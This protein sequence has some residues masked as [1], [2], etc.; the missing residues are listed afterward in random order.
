MDFPIFS[1]MPV[2]FL[3][4]YPIIVAVYFLL[5]ALGRLSTG[6]HGLTFMTVRA[7]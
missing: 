1:T 2:V 5:P 6:V 7:V 4:I 3:M